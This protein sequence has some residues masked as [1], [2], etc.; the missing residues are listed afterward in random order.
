MATP[1]FVDTSA[2]YALADSNDPDHPEA[3]RL[4]Q[5]IE[6]LRAAL[7]TSNFVISEIYTL[8]LKRVGRQLALS[9]VDGI[10]SGSTSVIRV[11]VEDEDR[12]WEILQLYQDQDF[13]Y[14]DATSFAFMERLGIEVFFAFDSHF[15]TF[16]TRKG[17]AFTEVK[18]L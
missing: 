10:R 16:R 11:A 7:V 4:L 15:N 14:V 8:L 3:V 2:H 17:Q 13:S 18:F 5:N 12:A 1:V 6:D 9:Y